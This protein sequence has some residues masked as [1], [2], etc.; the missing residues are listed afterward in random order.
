[1]RQK[2]NNAFKRNKVMRRKQTGI[3]L[4]KYARRVACI[5]DLGRHLHRLSPFVF[6][7]KN[8]PI[9]LEGPKGG[10][11]YLGKISLHPRK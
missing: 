8:A 11:D 10:K 2:V 6:G 1:M 3:N 5:L 4:C 7:K 9:K